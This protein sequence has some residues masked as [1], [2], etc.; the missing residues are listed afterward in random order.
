MVG[1]N[2]GGIE[3]Y[4]L[5]MSK[6]MSSDTVF[7][8]VIEGN[9][10]IHEDVIKELGGNIY[11]IAQRN[12]QP[13][14]NICDNWCLLKK[15]RNEIDAVYFNL[16][17]LSWLVPVSIAVKMKYRVYVHSH[18]S[19]F[20][21]QNGSLI[22]RIVNAINK[23]RLDKYDIKRLTCS[24]PATNFMFMRS[25]NVTMIYNA[26]N[27]DVF[28]YNPNIRRQIRKEL[29]IHNEFI[30]G[31][32][33]RI[34]YQKNPLYLPKIL[35]QV[36]S[37][38]RNVKMMIVGDGDMKDQLMRNISDL[39]VESSTL[40]LGNR[41][42][43]NE[44]MQA[45]DIFVLPSISEGLPYVVVEAQATGLECLIADTVTSEVNITNKVR[46]LPL[47]DSAIEWKR[48]IIQCMERTDSNRVKWAEYV[49]Q[50]DFNITKEAK[51][52][53]RILGSN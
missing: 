9:T 35:K 40:I 21:E 24:V 44:L 43:V 26:I 30:I 14:N 15:L 29:G 51:K 28:T 17:S 41:I 45:M 23:R 48:E 1:T 22:Y 7:D 18:N 37:D 46:F 8:Y 6:Y 53:E 5:K 39:G 49:K 16:S 19:K 25:D 27:T 20:N 11:Y 36:L 32:V 4:L 10:C 12:K 3:T 13:L 42:N 34:S 38:G 31:F 33:G 2:R 52:L 47:S 50:T